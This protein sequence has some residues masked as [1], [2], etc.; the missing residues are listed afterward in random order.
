MTRKP[1]D[2]DQW[3]YR[4]C[5]ARSLTRNS[6]FDACVNGFAIGTPAGFLRVGRNGPEMQPALTADRFEPFRVR[7][8]GW[9]GHRR[10]DRD[11]TIPRRHGIKSAADCF[12]ALVAAGGFARTASPR[13]SDGR[14]A[15][16]RRRH[17]LLRF[18]EHGGTR[19]H[20]CRRSRSR[21]FDMSATSRRILSGVGSDAALGIHHV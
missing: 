8:A 10:A 2:F 9:C 4:S 16:F 5:L 19:Q 20:G 17:R 18:H 15:A 13:S 12:A 6:G 1:F 7:Q 14:T 11:R 3:A 21:A